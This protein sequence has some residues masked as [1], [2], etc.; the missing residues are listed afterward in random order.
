MSYTLR[1]SQE[2][3]CFDYGWLKTCHTFS[4]DEYYDPN[5]MGFRSLRVINEDIIEPIHGFPLHGH[6]D[7]EIMTIVLE[8]ELTHQDSMGN[9]S[10]ITPGEVQVMSAGTGVTHSE[11][12]HS[13]TH[14]VHLLQIWI[15]PDKKSLAPQYQQKKFTI[16]PDSWVLIASKSGDAGSITIHQD[17]GVYFA[18]LHKG[19]LLTRNIAEHRYGWLQV[20]SGELQWDEVTLK[21]GDGVAIQSNTDISLKALAPAKIIFFDMN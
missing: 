17:I 19:G 2:R 1:R 21:S 13:D 12:N 7:M 5:Y 6:R 10:S 3:G 14:R 15:L 11:F 16:E 9:T 18:S 4:F 8:G 20:V